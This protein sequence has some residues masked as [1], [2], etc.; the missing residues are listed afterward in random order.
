MDNSVSYKK[1][2]PFCKKEFDSIYKYK[3]YCSLSCKNKNHKK[4]LKVC[5]FCRKEFMAWKNNAKFC[6]KKCSSISQRKYLNIPDCL[7]N[8]DRKLDKNIGYVRVYCPM[9]K[10]ANTWGYVYEHVVIAEQKLERELHSNEVVHHKDG[11]RWNNNPENLEVMD[12][13]EHSK[14]KKNIK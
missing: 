4:Y 6:S 5:D 14:L 8:A 7:E 2:C 12:R 13:I 1:V 9:H 3:K 10:K 11:L